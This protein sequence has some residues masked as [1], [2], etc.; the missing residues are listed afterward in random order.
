MQQGLD[1][2]LYNEVG[3]YATNDAFTAREKLAIEYAEQFAIDASGVSDDLIGR[4]RQHFTDVEIT[5]LT[6][7]N[8]FCLG[9]GRAL[10]ALDIQRDFDVLWSREPRPAGDTVEAS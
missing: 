6:V 3:S 4:M 2:D 9:F 10:T 8:A 5:E 7:T 1:D